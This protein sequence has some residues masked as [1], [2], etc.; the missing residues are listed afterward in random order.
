MID[1]VS[2]NL[3]ETKINPLSLLD[4]GFTSTRTNSCGRTRAR[5]K[6][7]RKIDVDTDRRGIGRKALDNDSLQTPLL[8]TDEDAF[9]SLPTVRVLRP[10]KDRTNSRDQANRRDDMMFL[11]VDSDCPSSSFRSAAQS[12]RRFIKRE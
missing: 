5:L 1:K 8:S 7:R 2:K 6:H 10:P 9:V 3:S 11:A 12:L 4:K